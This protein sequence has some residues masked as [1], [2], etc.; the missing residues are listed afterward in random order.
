MVWREG[1]TARARHLLL[2]QIFL[3]PRISLQILAKAATSMNS[4][5]ANKKVNFPPNLHPENNAPHP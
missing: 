5:F 2:H 3:S 4:I 1:R